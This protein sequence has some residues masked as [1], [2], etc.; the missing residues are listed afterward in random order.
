VQVH[1]AGHDAP[2]VQGPDRTGRPDHPADAPARHTVATLRFPSGIGVY[3]FT[4]GQWFHPLRRRHVLVRGTRGEV[5]GTSVTWAADDGR[6][7]DATIAR[8]Q[9][10]LDGDLEGAD[11]DTLTWAGTVLYRNPYR[12]A[13]LSDEEIAIGT[14]L[15]RTLRWR[16]GDGPPPYPLAEACQDHLLS[17]AIDEA[18]ASGPITTGR[19][20]WADALTADRA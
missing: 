1:A 5:V 12:G 3:D 2:L 8:R 17:L 10:G 7:L 19:E 16:R 18:A 15:E 4:D 9:T 11:L 14:V 20:P 6:P 13:R